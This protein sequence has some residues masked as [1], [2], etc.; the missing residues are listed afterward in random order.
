MKKEFIKNAALVAAR[1]SLGWIF[2]WAFLDKL[3]GLGFA[4]KTENAWLNGGSPTEYFLSNVSYGP[5]AGFYHAIAGHPV[6]DT[7][8]MAGLG[9]IGLALLLGV[10]L[11]IAGTSGA[12]MML[13]MWSSML[14]PEN[15]PLIDDH[16]VY[17]IVLIGL[18]HSDAGQHF[19]LSKKFT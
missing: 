5:L 18:A 10:Q 8:F 12:L 1:L 2:F 7:L 9:L 4:T 13:L 6:T 3:F 17:A 11:K 19:G 15:N 14:P 16:I